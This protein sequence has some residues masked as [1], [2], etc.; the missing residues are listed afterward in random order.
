[1]ASLASI[2]SIIVLLAAYGYSVPLEDKFPTATYPTSKFEF[3]T[4]KTI[5]DN[6]DKITAHLM[7]VHESASVPTV[8]IPRAFINK[9]TV[10]TPSTS[11][12][13]ER[14]SRES[15]MYVEKFLASTPLTHTADVP[16]PNFPPRG[17]VE[18]NMFDT[19]TFRPSTSSE[20]KL[21]IPKRAFKSIE[22]VMDKST[23][24]EVFATTTF[25]PST[26]SEEKLTI[27][28]RAFESNERV[29]DKSTSAEIF[30]T[31]TFRPSTSAE[32]KLTIPKRAFES[33]ERVT[34]KSTSAEVFATTPVFRG[35]SKE[36]TS[37]ERV[38][39]R[40]L[41]EATTKMPSGM[42]YPTTSGSREVDRS[43]EELTMRGSTKPTP[44]F[45]P[46]VPK[47]IN[48]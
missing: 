37:A 18:K 14:D 48:V 33:K 6:E 17:F 26:S 15:P 35:E 42:K 21:T 44:R 32:E 3:T 47:P 41:E 7:D 19:T 9:F 23:S 2:I 30:A 40:S 36:S 24:A 20:E 39:I 8:V 11:E 5:V 31:T 34:D 16:S 38:N 1:M 25:R 13:K 22:R 10:T 27:P 4:G 45:P 12:S 29:T 43:S 46:K 28:K